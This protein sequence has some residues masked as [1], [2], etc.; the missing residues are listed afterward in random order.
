MVRF[1]HTA[2]WQLGMTRHFLD[3]EA[4]GRFAQARIDVIQRMAGLATA[5][6]CAFVVVAGDVFET[7]QPDR[8]TLLRALDALQSFTVPVYLLPGN[9]DAYDPGSVFRSPAFLDRCPPHVE[10]LTD[11]QA[12]R[13]VDGVEVVGVPWTS[14]HPV[15]DLLAE[16]CASLPADGASRV[17]VGHGAADALSGDFSVPGT[18][19]LAEVEPA[20]EDGRAAYL[21]LGD[22]HST[23]RVGGTGRVWYAGAPEATD[24]DEWDPGNVL[25]VDLAADPPVVEPLSVGTWHFHLVERAVDGD[26]D[27]DL[28][29]ADL[30]AIGDKALAIVKLKVEGTLTLTQAARLE[31]ALEERADVF[32]ALEHPERHRDITI[33]PDVSDVAEL[34]LAGYA[35]IA[36]DRLLERAQASD[37]PARVATDALGLLVRLGDEVNR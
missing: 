34:P 6:G 9:H 27:L 28:L 20:V 1:L 10:V 29:L 16:V 24:Y 31:R 11:R 23:T 22:R 21:A 12:R 35:A 4:Q 13:P 8:T 5:H 25:V 19:R 33:A 36:R 37:D 15:T 32:G 14:K 17:V 18:F 30:D 2:D 26:V 7:N 3:A